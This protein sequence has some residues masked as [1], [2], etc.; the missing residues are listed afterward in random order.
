MNI[1]EMI[2]Q[3]EDKIQTME[4]EHDHLVARLQHLT[5]IRDEVGEVEVVSKSLAKASP[6]VRAFKRGELSAKIVEI[7]DAYRGQKLSQSRVVELM[8]SMEPDVFS[9]RTDEKIAST[10]Y[11]ALHRLSQGHPNI[12]R[13]HDGVRPAYWYG[14]KKK[15]G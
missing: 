8:K 5:E 11:A 15:K 10:M 12:R 7:L 9:G 3:T 4:A 2:K 14:R 1:K 6:K 13:E